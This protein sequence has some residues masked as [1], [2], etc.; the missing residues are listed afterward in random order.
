MRV[1]EYR[2]TEFYHQFITI[3][4]DELT[5]KLK[6]EYDVNEDDCYAL[7]SS[8][9]ARDGFLEFNVL[10]V[11]PDWSTCTKGLEKKEMLGSFTIDQVYDKEARIVDPDYSM[12]AKNAPFLEEMDSG[13]D[14]DFLKTRLDPRLDMLRDIAYPDLVLA[15]IPAND[16]I[17]EFEVRITGVKGPFLMTS[18]EEEPPEDIGIHLDDPLWTLPYIYDGVCHLYAMYAGNNLTNDQISERDRLINEMNRYGITFHG[19]KLRS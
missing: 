11:G 7:C 15:G 10:S 18:L 5:D 3:E 16:S 17:R 2:F 8:Y 9:C 4:A 1:D 6:D 13:Y 19:I 12:I 14:E